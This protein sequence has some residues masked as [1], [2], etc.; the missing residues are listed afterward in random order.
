M[1]APADAT[2]E[3][4]PVLR[5]LAREITRHEAEVADLPVAPNVSPGEIRETLARFDFADPVPLDQLLG[6]VADLL[7]RWSLHVNHPRYFGLFNPTV[8]RA[9]VV[10]D[11]LV[12]LYNPQ[13]A[14]WPHAPIANEIERHVLAWFMGAL[15]LDPTN[16]FATFTSGGQEANQTAVTVALTKAFPDFGE[17]GVRAL[18]GEPVF[19]TSAEAHHSFVKIAHL[20]GIGRDAVRHVRVDDRFRMDVEDLSRQ[21]RADRADGRLPFL[22]VGTAGTTAAG[23]IDPLAELAAIAQRERLWLHIDAAWGGAGVLSPTLREHLAGIE[24]ADSITCDAHKWL[25]VPMGAGMFFTRNREPVLQAFRVEASSYVPPAVPDT[26]DPYVTTVQWSRRF[27]GLKVF[28]TL[29]ELGGDG[30]AQQIERQAAM[31]DLLRE[32]LAAAGWQLVND[33][34]LAIVC[35]THPEIEAGRT[36]TKAVIDR[37]VG[38]GN[39]WISEVRLS[40]P[41]VALRACITSHRTSPADIDILVDELERAVRPK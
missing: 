11:A 15:G 38:R 33:S 13:L 41:I 26:D 27:I 9:G 17:H 4:D 12:A 18:S 39:A 21:I 6:D 40:G 25:S 1:T 10:A 2:S 23:A 7:R 22:I 30:M 28:M 37:V 36:T 29:A 32:R 5:E 8:R 19:Y 3:I 35:F 34:P 14:A 31:G 20:S 16:G 24:L